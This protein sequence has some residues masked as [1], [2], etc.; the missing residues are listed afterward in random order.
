MPG[1]SSPQA[2]RSG[3]EE[4]CLKTRLALSAIVVVL[5]SFGAACA[6]KPT[7]TAVWAPTTVLTAFATAV[8]TPPPTS[9]AAAGQQQAVAGETV[10]ATY[11]SSCHDRVFS[12]S[13]LARYRTAEGFFN[14]NRG[15]MPPAK[16]GSLTDQQY[17][18]VTAYCLSQQGLLTPEQI[19]NAQTAAT[20]T[21]TQ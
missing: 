6:A 7:P 14:Y 15:R 3:A 5:A 18:D 2:N 20:I 16:P 13:L 12:R 4:T 8:P 10:F 11:C 21:L 19:V 1:T 17:Y 9:A